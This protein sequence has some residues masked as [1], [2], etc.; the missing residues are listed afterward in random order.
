[1]I[2]NVYVN[3]E[4]KERYGGKVIEKYNHRPGLPEEDFFPSYTST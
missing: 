1:M 3:L 4:N 2:L